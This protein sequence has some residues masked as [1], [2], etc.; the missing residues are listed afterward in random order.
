MFI[1]FISRDT[2]A[3]M[4]TNI[5]ES[6]TILISTTARIPTLTFLLNCI[7][8]SVSFLFFLFLRVCVGTVLT[9]CL[10]GSCTGCCLRRRVSVEEERLRRNNSPSESES[11]ELL[12]GAKV[13]NGKGDGKF[14]PKSRSTRAEA[15]V[16]LHRLD[17][18]KK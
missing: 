18:L 15:V 3:Y 8:L 1:S 6:T 9:L 17:A 4:P 2:A 5:P 10:T 16:I 12:A 13:I 7:C 14:E 11:V